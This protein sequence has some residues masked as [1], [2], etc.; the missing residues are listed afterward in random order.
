M[1][2]DDE[3]RR[4]PI[5]GTCTMA[6]G[7]EQLNGKAGRAEEALETHFFLHSFAEDLHNRQVG[8]LGIH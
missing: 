8:S 5:R 6:R 7:R 3:K 2:I 1:D 4:V